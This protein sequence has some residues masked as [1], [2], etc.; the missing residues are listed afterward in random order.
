MRLSARLS[1]LEKALSPKKQPLNL[2][3]EEAKVFRYEIACSMLAADRFPN[4]KERF[5]AIAEEFTAEVKSR[6]L[7]PIEDL[8]P[9]HAEYVRQMWISSGRKSQYISPLVGSDYDGWWLPDLMDRRL[10]VRRRPSI[11]ALISASGH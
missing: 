11:I 9:R 3:G 1:K 4:L 7:Q 2:T 5:A 6:L 10:A 8:Y